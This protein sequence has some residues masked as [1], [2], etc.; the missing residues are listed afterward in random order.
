MRTFAR[1]IATSAN[2]VTT[3]NGDGSWVAKP[4]MAMP[5]YAYGTITS[6][7]P[8]VYQY[9]LT[10]VRASLRSGSDS[11]SRATTSIR[12]LNEPQVAGP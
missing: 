8:V 5:Y 12:V 7:D 9:L 6:P 3:N 2:L 4:T 10:D 1:A 11:L